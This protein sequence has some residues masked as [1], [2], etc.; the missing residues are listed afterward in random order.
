MNAPLKIGVLGA[1]HL[2]RIHIQQVREVP[3]LELVGFH[4]PDQSKC[5][6]VQAE[7][8]G[9]IFGSPGEL[10]SAVDVLDVVTP[11]LSHHA[12]ARLALEAGKPVFIEKPLAND[13]QEADD[14]VALASKTGIKV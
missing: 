7:F 6:A 4:D 11:T 14:L 10:L 13:M 8:G 3:E 9:T 1:G 5:E 2:G 12:M